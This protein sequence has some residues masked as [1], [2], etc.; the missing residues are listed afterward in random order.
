[1]R[2]IA[3]FDIT[4]ALGWA[5]ALVG[6]VSFQAR[7]RETVIVLLAASC[8]LW[9]SHYVALGMSAGAIFNFI[10][11]LR[12]LTAIIRHPWVRRGVLLFIPLIW[13]VALLT[14]KQPIDYIP[15]LA[16][17]MSTLAQASSRVVWLRLFM[18]L[19]SPPWLTYA[20]LAGSQ[21]GI[22]NELLNMGSVA[23]SL[24]RYHLRPRLAARAAR[25]RGRLA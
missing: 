16:M 3:A 20:I 4:Q 17:T 10:A 22:A 14:A 23:L 9:T 8:L 18:G 15:P 11:M 6:V 12:G 7:R 21:G 19:S 13:T 1:M 24:Y 2:M 5:A 25:R